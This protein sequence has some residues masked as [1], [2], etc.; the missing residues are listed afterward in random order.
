MALGGAIGIVVG[1][2]LGAG[3]LERA[4][5]TARKMMAFSIFCAM[6][7]ALLL[8]VTSTLFPGLYQTTDSVRTLA[9]YMIVVSAALLPFCAYAHGAYFTLRSGG[10]VAVTILFDS[11]YMWAL[12]APLVWLL[13]RFTS[14]DI[15]WL[16]LAGQSVEII[17]CI[18]G[19]L[20]LSKTN[21]AKQLVG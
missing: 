15:H 6:A 3:K 1:N 10:K 2:E 19:Y 4:R 20:L 9:S 11:V 7:M 13:S 16:F 8:V 17:K 18:F 5:D 14:M 12:V 21:W